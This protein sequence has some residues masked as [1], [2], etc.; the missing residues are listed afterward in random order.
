MAS[1]L[2]CIGSN[3]IGINNIIRHKKNGLLIDKINLNNSIF[4]NLNNK[5]LI[6]KI[7]INS[8]KYITNN[9]SLDVIV[10]ELK[11]YNVYKKS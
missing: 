5:K 10:K 4:S 6:K 3:V 8:R 11:I 9:H 1:E 7:N 2:L